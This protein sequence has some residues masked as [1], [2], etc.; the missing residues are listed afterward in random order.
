MKSTL[1]RF[2]ISTVF[3]ILSVWLSSTVLNLSNFSFL[4]RSFLLSFSRV[5]RW[6][7]LSTS[8][9][10]WNESTNHRTLKHQNITKHSIFSPTIG[11]R[12]RLAK[13]PAHGENRTLIMNI[14]SFRNFSKHFFE[15]IWRFFESLQRG[16]TGWKSEKYWN[17]EFFVR[18]IIR[19]T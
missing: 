4:P 6:I 7:R 3:F 13:V 2:I 16:T 17:D 12:K 8:G 1:F 11:T 18:C 15:N 19:R 14:W 9:K 5:P 10:T